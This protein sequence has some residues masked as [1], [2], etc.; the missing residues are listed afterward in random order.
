MLTSPSKGR[1]KRSGLSNHGAGSEKRC[2]AVAA[3]STSHSVPLIHTW[4]HIVTTVQTKTSPT[5]DP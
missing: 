1:M 2:V 5:D 3:C 4:Q